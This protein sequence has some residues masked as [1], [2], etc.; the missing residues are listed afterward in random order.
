MRT[1]WICDRAASFPG[2]T[3]IRSRKRSVTDL[4]TSLAAVVAFLE[5]AEVKRQT[6]DAWLVPTQGI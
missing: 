1:N 2:G 6:N 5:V 4:A 3:M